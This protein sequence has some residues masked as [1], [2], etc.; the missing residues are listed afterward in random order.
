VRE[1]LGGALLVDGQYREAEKVLR[2]DL[3]RNPRNGRSLFGLRESLKAQKKTADAEWVQ[4]AF[5]AAWQ[6]ADSQLRA[7]GL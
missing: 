3:Q 5:A 2:A 1:S 4:K 6:N 7:E